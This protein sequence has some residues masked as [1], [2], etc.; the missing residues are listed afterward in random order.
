[1]RE[2]DNAL[3]SLPGVGRRRHLGRRWPCEPRAT[4][5]SLVLPAVPI[6][7]PIVATVAVDL[8][9]IAV[10][11]RLPARPP[12]HARG[13]GARPDHSI[14]VRAQS[15]GDF[16]VVGPFDGEMFRRSLC[17]TNL[18]SETKVLADLGYDADWIRGFPP[19][20]VAFGPTSP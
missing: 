12:H 2:T 5:F 14:N 11:L 15:I 13:A 9:D 4:G 8:L 19:N 10:L 18:S 1:M 20:A 16:R 3:P 17:H 7:M 6:S